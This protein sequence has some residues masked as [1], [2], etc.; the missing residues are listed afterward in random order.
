MQ[1]ECSKWQSNKRKA[2]GACL[3][4]MRSMASSR[5]PGNA[6]V[7]LMSMIGI[8]KACLP[9]DHAC[10]CGAG[11]LPVL[12]EPVGAATTML[13]SFWKAALKVALCTGLKY[14]QRQQLAHQ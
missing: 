11:C 6:D 5:T 7:I 3:R 10:E 9:Q 1:E 4:N 13:A 12:P 14:L 2:A 8:C